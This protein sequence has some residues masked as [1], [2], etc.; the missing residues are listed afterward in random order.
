MRRITLPD[1]FKPLPRFV[2]LEAFYS[3]DEK[4]RISPEWDYGVHWCVSV[5]Q[6]WPQWRLSWVVAT[7]DVYAVQHLGGTVVVLGNVPAVGSYPIFPERW[8]DWARKQTIEQV[9][10]GW[11]HVDPPLLTWPLGRLRVAA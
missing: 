4:R 2:S 6:R 5:E 11:A 8:R 1:E 10:D 3:D 9:L 7:G